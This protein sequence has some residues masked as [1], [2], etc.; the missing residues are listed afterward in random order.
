MDCRHSPEK[1]GRSWWCEQRQCSW[2]GHSTAILMD[3]WMT[4]TGG[5]RRSTPKSS[6]TC[7]SQMKW[8][9]RKTNS[10]FTS[11]VPCRVLLSTSQ[12]LETKISF[13]YWITT[14]AIKANFHGLYAAYSKLSSFSR[15]EPVTSFRFNLAF[16]V[17][18]CVTA[19]CYHRCHRMDMPAP[20]LISESL[21]AGVNRNWKNL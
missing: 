5:E 11:N 6:T 9:R 2:V 17:K 13:L 1:P 14:V 10:D 8:T 12:L 7:H 19:A 20:E 16:M 3:T 21:Y 15:G 18:A 4:Q